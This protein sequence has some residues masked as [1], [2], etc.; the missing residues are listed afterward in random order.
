MKQSVTDLKS[1]GTNIL[2]TDVNLRSVI[3]SL[4]YTFQTV[5]FMVLVVGKRRPKTR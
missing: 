5:R 1:I 2:G 3:F 4:L